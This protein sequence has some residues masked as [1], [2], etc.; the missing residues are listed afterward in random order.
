[1]RTEPDGA[2][3][4]WITS[5]TPGPRGWRSQLSSP[6]PTEASSPQAPWRAIAQAGMIGVED[7]AG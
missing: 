7:W 2:G 3:I 6:V 1:M 5:P 4:A